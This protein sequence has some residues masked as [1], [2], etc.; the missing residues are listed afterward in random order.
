VHT[1][2]SALVEA[3]NLLTN[4]TD[5]PLLDAEILLLSVLEKNRSYLR[6]WPELELTTEQHT[7]FQAL[8]TQ[9]R[10]G[11]P[12]AYLIGSR[13]FWSRDFIITP[14]VLIPRPE[15]ELLVELSLAILPVN[16]SRRILDLGTGSGIIAVTLA[17]ERPKAQVSATDISQKA[18]RVAVDNAKKHNVENIQFYLSNWFDKVPQVTYDLIVSNP[19]YIAEKDDHLQQGDLR[20]EPKTA[21]VSPEQGLKDIRTIAET[22]LKRLKPGGYLI[23]EHGYNQQHEIYN[24]FQQLGY[25]NLQSHSDLSGQPRVTLGQYLPV[26]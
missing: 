22:S 2:K 17:S 15:T 23:V 25:Q 8:I 6:T 24:L 26:T 18:L 12:V 11:Q 9:R 3:V 5:T 10:L 4:F 21:L 14:D 7:G 16:Q 20:F 19:P 1:L 13:E